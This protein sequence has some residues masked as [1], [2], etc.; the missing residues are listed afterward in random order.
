VDKHF[1][2]GLLL[3]TA[4]YL[5]A[6]WLIKNGTTNVPGTGT[7]NGN[8]QTGG[9]NLQ[10]VVQNVKSWINSNFP[11]IGEADAVEAAKEAVGAKSDQELY[12]GN[13][14]AV[15][16]L[17]G[18]DT[19]PNQNANGQGQVL[20]FNQYQSDGILGGG[21]YARFS[22]DKNDFFQARGKDRKTLTG[23]IQD[24]YTWSFN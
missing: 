6:R 16:I 3:F 2:K 14:I 15:G 23:K 11:E 21:G 12:P 22:P 1:L 5:T 18:G 9:V 8:L 20:D 13:N 24:D 10:S 4:G 17:D 19:A 7:S